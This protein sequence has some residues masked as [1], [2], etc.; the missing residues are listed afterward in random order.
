MPAVP[1]IPDPQQQACGRLAK[2][3][4]YG[5]VASFADASFVIDRR[6][7]LVIPPLTAARRSVQIGRTGLLFGTVGDMDQR[8]P[9]S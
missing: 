7:G 2:R 1:I 3:L 6:A 4:A 5:D 8:I 9:D